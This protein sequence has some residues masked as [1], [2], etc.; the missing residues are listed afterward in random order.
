MTLHIVTTEQPSDTD[1]DAIAAPL[2]VY[3]S[4]RA[5][6]PRTFPVAL[7]LTD[8]DGKQVGGLWG[9]R[10]YD[11]FFVELLTVPETYRGRGYGSELMGRA[12]QVA[13]EHKCIGIWLDT[14]EFQ[15]RGFYEKFGFEVF[16]AL[17]D[18]PVGHKRFFL[19]KYLS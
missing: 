2:I 13:R 14:F 9:E 18:H 5:G 19:C 6:P 15:A 3:N 16:G 12:E 11:W 1:R 4:S 7:M 17:D 8:E 10:V